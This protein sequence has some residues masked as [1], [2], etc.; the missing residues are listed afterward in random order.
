MLK[1]RSNSKIQCDETESCSD[2]V[3]DCS[4]I[5]D[6]EWNSIKDGPNLETKFVKN[7]E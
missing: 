1:W 5:L 4:K 7:D 2:N 3:D 6:Y